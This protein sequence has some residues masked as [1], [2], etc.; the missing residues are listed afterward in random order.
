MSDAEQIRQAAL[1]ALVAGF[2][3]RPATMRFDDPRGVIDLEGTI[4]GVDVA[5]DV[6]T[7][8]V[9][10]RDGRWTVRLLSLLAISL[11]R[12]TRIR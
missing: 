1:A 5:S 2:V 4:V 11:D 6:F 8:T 12:S 9:D 7:V 3:G 10:R